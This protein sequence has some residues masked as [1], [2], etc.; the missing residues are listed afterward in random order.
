MISLFLVRI[1]LSDNQIILMRENLVRWASGSGI[2][3]GIFGF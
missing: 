3:V 2:T 1:S